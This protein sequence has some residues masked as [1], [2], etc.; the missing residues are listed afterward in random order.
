MGGGGV[1]VL[2]DG[3]REQL[4]ERGYVLVENVVPREL[5]EAVVDAIG[6]FLG[7]DPRD[8]ADWYKHPLQGHGIVPLHHDQALWDVRQ[9]PRVYQLFCDVHGHGKL[10]VTQDRV[11]FK[12]PAAGFTN[13]PRV[14]PVHWDARPHELRAR[15]RLSVQ[16]LVY[17]TDTAPDQG[18]FACVPGL[19]RDIDAWLAAHPPDT[20]H[21][22]YRDEDLVTVAGPQGSMVLWHRLMPHTSVRNDGDL[23]RM[24]QYVTM[25]DDMPA[26]TRAER[27][28]DCLEK[29]A[30]AWALA[31]KVPGQVSPEPGPPPVL[32]ALGRRLAEIEPW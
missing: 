32:T 27:V 24:V 10:T 3:E 11:S 1:N 12:P 17:L 2:S 22:E 23:P 9:H 25:A 29:R 16:G 19:Y 14:D 4:L 8:P 18:G 31:Q 13:Q 15:G 6:R 28:R 30:P 5:C 7:I 21:P 26:A 20:R